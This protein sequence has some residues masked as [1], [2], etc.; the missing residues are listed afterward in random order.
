MS[1]RCCFPYIY[2][3]C[4]NCRCIF[5]FP[6]LHNTYFP[7]ERGVFG[8]LSEFHRILKEIV[9]G[10]LQKGVEDSQQRTRKEELQKREEKF[11]K[12]HSRG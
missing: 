11:E 12:N 1:Q 6:K 2:Y 4:I 7:C 3:M 9:K 5:I 10:R 8:L